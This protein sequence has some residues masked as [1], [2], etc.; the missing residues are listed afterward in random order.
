[1]TDFDI[2]HLKRTLEVMLRRIENTEDI[3]PEDRIF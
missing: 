3:R 2:H 1:M